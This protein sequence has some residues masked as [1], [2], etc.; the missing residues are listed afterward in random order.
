MARINKRITSRYSKALLDIAIEQG[1]GEIV[2]TDM[3]LIDEVVLASDELRKLLRNKVVK[4]YRKKKIMQAIFTAKVNKLSMAFI[5]LIIEK[6]HEDIL[7]A[8]IAEYQEAYKTHL[9]IQTAYVTTPGTLTDP[10]RNM[11]IKK[12]MDFT[13]KKIDLKEDS[14]DKLIGG[15]LLEVGDYRFDAS[16]Q[17]KF[18][19]LSREF[20]KNI[21]EKG[22]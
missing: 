22:Y 3:V 14:D 5:D 7:V 18:R 10:I 11:L 6:R 13:G 1:I 21:Y 16:L 19:L 12:L 15:Y 4:T 9:G 17:E 2:H 20:E 8:I